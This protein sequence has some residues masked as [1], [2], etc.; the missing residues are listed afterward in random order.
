MLLGA[1]V[2]GSSCTVVLLHNHWESD[3]CILACWCSRQII[4]TERLGPLLNV[5][6]WHPCN[7]V[8][9]V[10]LLGRWENMVALWCD[11]MPGCQC[12]VVY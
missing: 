12:I 6:L 9:T 2:C 4:Q 1:L 10:Q 3:S 11:S 8:S 7:R 5:G